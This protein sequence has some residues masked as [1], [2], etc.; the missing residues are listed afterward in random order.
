M[1]E[2]CEAYRAIGATNEQ[3]EVYRFHLALNLNCTL[4]WNRRYHYTEVEIGNQ[5]DPS[6]ITVLRRMNGHGLI[7][8]AM[9]FK[10]FVSLEELN[11]SKLISFFQNCKNIYRFF[12]F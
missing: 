11:L 5:Y 6:S 8:Q 12:F 1:T 2:R 4:P 3:V 9:N 10:R 7:S